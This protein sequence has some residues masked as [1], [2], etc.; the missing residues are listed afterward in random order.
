MNSNKKNIALAVLGVILLG[1]TIAYAAL[2]TNL[3]IGGS[4][5]V[6]AVSWNVHFANFEKGTVTGSATGPSAS[7]LTS[8]GHLTATSISNLNISLPRPGD[9]ITYTWDIVNEG[10]IE[11]KLNSYSAGWT[12]DSGKDCS[13]ITYN[14][15]CTNGA[16]TQNS[17]LAATTGSASCTLTVSRAEATASTDSNQTYSD[18]A[19]SGSI[20]A[21]WN[22]VQN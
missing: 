3:S 9:S 6:P 14:L 19:A 8:G 15:T 20:N 11:A 22:Y 2:Q 10:S 4:V 12:C 13:N 17:T 7:E 1:M 5:N 21:T 18:S 16:T